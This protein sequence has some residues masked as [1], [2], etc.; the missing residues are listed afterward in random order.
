M[1]AISRNSWSLAIRTVFF[2]AEP[3]TSDERADVIGCIQSRRADEGFEVVP[4]RHID[5]TQDVARLFSGLGKS[6]KNQVNRAEKHDALGCT[7]AAQPSDD[8]ILRFRDFY[9]V[10]ARAK[11]T[12]LCRRYQVETMK[13]L[14][15]QNGLAISRVTDSLGQALCYHVYVTD[16]TRAM[17]LY[18]G[19]HFRS[20][21][22][23]DERKRLARANR[24]LHWKD[25]L[26][27][28]QSGFAIY[29]FGGLTDDPGI[30]E[31]KRSFGGRDVAEYTGY[32][33]VTWKG[34]VAARYRGLLCSVRRHL[35]SPPEMR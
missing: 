5:L 7:A 33:P 12:T 16:G 34:R 28:K 23:Q 14:A 22:D 15:R 27:F 30:A 6:T 4:T 10:F 8:D 2:A 26:Y 18:S 11:G 13:L 19:S 20:I 9:N 29:D 17:L 3:E 1:I 31:F 32:V 24:L 35:F 21:Q 25:I